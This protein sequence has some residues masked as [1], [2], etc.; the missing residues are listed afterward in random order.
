MRVSDGSPKIIL[1]HLSLFRTSSSL[2][3]NSFIS[4]LTHSHHT[5]L[6]LPLHALLTISIHFFTHSSSD[7]LI[8]CPNHLNLPTLTPSDTESTPSC[9][10]NFS[11]ATLSFNL[12]PH[13][14]LIIILSVLSRR[15]ISSTF[16]GQVS[17]P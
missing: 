8:T 6:L 10:L 4:L 13:I 16:T 5:F 11:G 15:C 7:F 9:F 1:L 12:T 17:L 3:P 14:H 2:K